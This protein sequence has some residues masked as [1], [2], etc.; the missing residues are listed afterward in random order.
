[1]NG[2]TVAIRENYLSLLT[3]ALRNNLKNLKG[4]DEPENNLSERDVERCAIELEYDAF[5][6]STVISLY[7]RAMAKVVSNNLLFNSYSYLF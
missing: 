4:I 1:M 2:L 7:R 5:S 3:D 6:N